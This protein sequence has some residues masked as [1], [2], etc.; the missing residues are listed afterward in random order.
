M[1]KET[2]AY[3]RHALV[4]GYADKL[5]EENQDL[6][7]I[8]TTG[9][10]RRSNLFA[11]HIILRAS[12]NDNALTFQTC[13]TAQYKE[14]FWKTESPKDDVEGGLDTKRIIEKMVEL[15]QTLQPGLPTENS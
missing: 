15:A 5:I 12:A 2:R 4:G 14:A 6:R 1:A 11:D 10:L 7:F 8:A 13:T 9:R 3:K